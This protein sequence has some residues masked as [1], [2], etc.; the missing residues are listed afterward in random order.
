MKTLKNFQKL[1]LWLELK[2]N[3]NKKSRNFR[4]TTLLHLQ[5]CTAKE[6]QFW[7][8]LK[9]LWKLESQLFFEKLLHNF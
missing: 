4:D 7:R 8:R 5:G 6:A 1:L 3:F 9:D 2:H